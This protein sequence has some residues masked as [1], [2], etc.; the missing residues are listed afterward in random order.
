MAD[1][2]KR[3]SITLSEIQLSEFDIGG[4]L[5][6]A[7]YFHIYERSREA[8]L[9]SIGYPYPQL[10]EQGTHLAVTESHQQFHRPVTYG[11]SIEIS[12]WLTALR[13]CSVTF[14][15][16]FHDIQ[17]WKLTGEIN[18]EHKILHEAWTTH[19]FVQKGDTGFRVCR[20]PEPFL[21]ATAPYVQG[22]S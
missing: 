21:S 9:K 19:A 11:Q 7:N 15:Y 20:F 16:L 12:L 13:S 14:N 18:T 4:V 3:F 10:V 6:H 17:N 22:R 8:F 2:E 5:Y 1:N